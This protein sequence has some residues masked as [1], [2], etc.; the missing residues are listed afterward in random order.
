MSVTQLVTSLRT[1]LGLSS[2]VPMGETVN[3]ACHTLGVGLTGHIKNDAALAYAHSPAKPGIKPV[4][5]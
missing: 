2:D 4:F 3:T 1:L 5:M